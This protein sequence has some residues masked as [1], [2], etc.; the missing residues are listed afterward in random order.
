M[1]RIYTSESAFNTDGYYIGNAIGTVGA[2]RFQQCER[3]FKNQILAGQSAALLPHLKKVFLNKEDKIY[4]AGEDIKDIYF[5]EN[6]VISEYQILEDGRTSELAMV[7]KEGLTGLEVVLNSGTAS[8][9]MRVSVAGNALKIKSAVLKSEFDRN[10]DFRETVLNYLHQYCKQ[11]S[12]KIICNCYHLIENRLCSWLL[13]LRERSGRDDF[14]MTQEQI[15]Y[16]LGVHRPS[17]TKA[18]QDMRKRKILVY[19][20][21]KILITD[22][23]KLENTACSCYVAANNF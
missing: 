4:N 15:A 8:N 10:I 22:S 3:F 11:A 9:W 2:S 14:P 21:G 12:L 18:M 7:G 17:I 1:D 20:R 23:K 13:M 5:P 6:A 19:K 16:F